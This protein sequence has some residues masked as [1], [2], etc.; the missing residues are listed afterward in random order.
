MLECNGWENNHEPPSK[1]CNNLASLDF[2]IG[3]TGIDRMGLQYQLPKWTLEER[4]KLSCSLAVLLAASVYILHAT[5]YYIRPKY[6]GTMY[7]MYVESHSRSSG[8]SSPD[9]DGSG[10]DQSTHLP[11]YPSTQASKQALDGLNGLD[12]LDG[13]MADEDRL[14]C[15]SSNES[16]AWAWI[17]S[18]HRSA[19]AAV[20]GPRQAHLHVAVGGGG[21]SLEKGSL[22]R[23]LQILGFHDRSHL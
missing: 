15:S 12:G 18:A 3:G 21:G 23:R 16:T 22:K 4:K 2:D 9:T 14:S 19:Q 7:V 6:V 11:I 17:E 13:W 8:L 1:R 5:Y 20:A 10:R